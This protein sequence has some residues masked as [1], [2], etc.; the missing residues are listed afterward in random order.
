MGDEKKDLLSNVEQKLNID[1][2]VL[3]NKTEQILEKAVVKKKVGMFRGIQSR[4]MI[5]MLVTALVS[6]GVVMAIAIAQ[7]RLALTERVT[8]DMLTMVNAYGVNL[9]TAVY[10][11]GNEIPN[12]EGLQSMFGNVKLDGMPSSYIYVVKNDGTMLMHPTTSKIGQP[13]EN[14]VVSGVVKQLQNGEVPEAKVVEYDFKGVAK[15]AAYY[16]LRSGKGMLVLTA[17]KEEAFDAVNQFIF[18][19]MITGLFILVLVSIGGI[20]ISRSIAKPIKLLT[21]VVDKN[22][23]FDFT[24]SKISR[25]LSKGK[26]ETAVM[27]SSL[28]TMRG[29]LVGMVHKLTETAKKLTDNADGLKSIVENLNSNSC[30]NSAISQQLAASMDETSTTTQLIDERMEDINNN[31]KKIGSLTKEG[32]KNAAEIITKAEKLKTN[33]QEANHKTREIYSKVKQES[34]IAI[35]RAKDIEQI[36]ALTDAIASIATQ[37]ELLS[38]NASI[39][40]ARA[41]EAGRG[42]AV[43]AGEIGSL[44]SQSTEMANSISSIVVEVKNAAESMETCLLQMISFME[45]TVIGDY[46]NFIQVSEEYSA[47]AKNFSGSMKTINNS[48][49]GLEEN[50]ANI[51]KSIQDINTT[52]N[53]AALSINEVAVK[54][55]DMVKYASDTGDRAEENTKCAEELDQIVR[56]FKI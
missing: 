38:L 48:V 19:C 47:D 35:Q 12:A 49:L 44:A 22:A 21:T 13:V 14:E 32:E 39:E 2:E 42:F 18:Q 15:L 37:T 9:E 55:T 53:E 20:L 8:G 34:D 43:V 33:S 4:V 52:V 30:D 26:G 3:E 17:D 16:V 54:A 24:E 6:V 51:T 45:E 40:A 31:T 50:I 25:L 23:E 7:T 56:W 41:G 28:E 27:S 36:N 5:A 29:N 10:T 46:E 11:R 1:R